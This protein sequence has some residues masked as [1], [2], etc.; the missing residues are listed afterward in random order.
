MAKAKAKAPTKTTPAKPGK[1]PGGR[2]SKYDPATM[3]A[4]AEKV[5]RE[6]GADDE[7][8]ARFFDVSVATINNWKNKHPEFL[9]SLRAG[10]D[11]FDTE[12]VE[13]ALVHR[14]IG[15]SHPEDDIRVANGEII[16]TPT[17][18]HYPPDT[19]AAIFWLKN[20]DKDRWRDKIEH[21]HGL[22]EG[23]PIID[24]MSQIAGNTLRPRTDDSES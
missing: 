17:I 24:L 3:P 14:A 2:P 16:I 13:A 20:R 21:D 9:E 15:Y 19:T 4:L 11:Y 8:L 22:Q 23:N 7:A 6:F 18:K 1:H 5:C 10:K 12:R